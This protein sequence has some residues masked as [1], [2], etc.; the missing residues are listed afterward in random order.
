MEVFNQKESSMTY[1]QFSALVF[2]IYKLWIGFCFLI[3]AAVG[4]LSPFAAFVWMVSQVF[5]NAAG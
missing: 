4:V 1:E 3:G 2:V 5:S